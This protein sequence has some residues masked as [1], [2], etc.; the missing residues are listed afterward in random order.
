[1]S[2]VSAF[3]TQWSPGSVSR[4]FDV[5]IGMLYEVTTD[6]LVVMNITAEFFDNEI[7]DSPIVEEDYVFKGFFAIN[8]LF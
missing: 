2:V 8:Y 4:R 1:M 3:L 5:G 7:T 6:W